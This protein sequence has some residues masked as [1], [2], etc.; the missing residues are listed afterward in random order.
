VAFAVLLYVFFRK[1]FT[2]HTAL[3]IVLIFVYNP[4]VLNFKREVMADLPFALFLLA[5]VMVYRWPRVM[6]N[7]ILTGLVAGF[8]ICLKG[9]GWA[10]VLAVIVT[11]IYEFLKSD[12]KKYNFG[13]IY[14]HFNHTVIISVTAVFVWF[15]VEKLIFNVSSGYAVNFIQNNVLLTIFKNL[16]YYQ[17]VGMSFLTTNH[18]YTGFI[19]VFAG[20]GALVCVMLGIIKRFAQ[21]V[22][23]DW[24]FAVF[25]MVLLVYPYQ[26]SGFRFLLPL[27]PLLLLYGSTGFGLM[28]KLVTTR[29]KAAT[30][31]C[32]LLII[33]QYLPGV[34][35]NFEINGNEIDGPQESASVNALC[36][37]DHKLPNGTIVAFCKPRALALYSQCRGFAVGSDQKIY[38]IDKEFND[39]K[40]DYFLLNNSLDDKNL[41]RWLKVRADRVEKVW[42]NSRFELYR[43]IK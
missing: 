28:L 39:F 12:V 17:E 3:L 37:L 23:E 1:Q 15:V 4:L 22:F 18:D 41:E 14:R 43:R 34:I 9:I 29:T 16:S 35:K 27:I 42:E 19:G 7:S 33:F 26:G 25:M 36:Y 38:E 8:L 24:L 20:A 13:T 21:P 10:F 31:I 6:F 5:G 11:S 32:S 30:I 2:W 40:I